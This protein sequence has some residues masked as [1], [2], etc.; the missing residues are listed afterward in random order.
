MLFS[1]I[2]PT[3]LSLTVS[4]SL[5][6]IS[7]SPLLP[8]CWDCECHLSRFCILMW[9]IHMHW[10]A[11]FIFLS[12]TYFTLY[13]RLWVHPPHQ[14]WLKC[15]PFYGWVIFHCVPVSQLPYPFICRWTSRLL[16][17]LAILNSAEMN[18]GVDVSFLRHISNYGFLRICAQQW[19]WWVI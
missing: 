7:V 11:I 6:F 8:C 13:N 2:I 16:P 18:T 15:V 12:L 10:Y 14:N 5:F 19:D 4:K 9:N 3:S 1:Q 17:W